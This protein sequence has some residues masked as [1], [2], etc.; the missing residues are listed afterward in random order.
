M[1]KIRILRNLDGRIY[2]AEN[3]IASAENIRL[4]RPHTFRTF[5]R[6]RM[7]EISA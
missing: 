2:A 3:K 5:A 6:G 7:C 4:L 1:R